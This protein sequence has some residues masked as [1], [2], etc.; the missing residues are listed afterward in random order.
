MRRTILSLAL[1]LVFS[2]AGAVLAAPGKVDALAL[3]PNDAAS[4]GYIRLADLRSSPLAMTLLSETDRMSCDGDAEK[5]LAEAGLQPAKDIDV[6]VLSMT[7]RAAFGKEA[8]LL[9][10]AEGRFNVARLAAA[11]T[12]RGAVRK[13]GYFVLPEESEDDGDRP[14]IAF[15]SSSLALVGTENGVIQGLKNLAAGGTAFLTA[16]GLGR[17]ASRIDARASAWALIDVARVTRLS[18]QPG[19]DSK[20]PSAQTVHAALNKVSTVALWA[21]DGGD[22]LQLGAF[23]LARDEETLQLVE[24]AVRGALAAMRLAAS[25]SSPELVPVLRKFLVTRSDDSVTLTG[26]IPAGILRNLAAKKHAGK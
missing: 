2:F 11:L 23:G 4:V 7:P 20:Q 5:F 25:E 17:E 18:R 9:V 12:S 26:S 1:I 14:V 13:N 15:P 8:D 10:A 16:S 19:I 22:S 6:L 3:V 24:D 21:T